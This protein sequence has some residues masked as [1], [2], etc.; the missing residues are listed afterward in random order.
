MESILQD[1]YNGDL[2]PR[3]NAGQTAFVTYRE[4]FQTVLKAQAPELEPK[5]HT[6][7]NELTHAN[8]T[9]T[10]NMFYAGFSL[11]VKLFTAALSYEQ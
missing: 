3:E 9:E 7:M 4:H 11:A 6:L 8:I 10:E 1:L 2:C 5:F